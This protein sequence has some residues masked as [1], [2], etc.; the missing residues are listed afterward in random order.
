[1]K[2]CFLHSNADSKELILFF[3]GFASEPSHF[4]HLSSSKNVLM[5]YEYTNFDIDFD[6]NAFD[7]VTLIAFSMGV[8]IAAILAKDIK[9][10]IDYKIAINGTNYGIHR[11]YGIHPLIFSKTIENLNVLEFRKMLF[12]NHF[13]YMQGHYFRSKQ[14]LKEEL[15]SLYTFVMEN[16][17]GSIDF[18]YDKALL[19]ESDLVFPYSHSKKFFEQFFPNAFIISKDAPHFIFLDIDSWDK[20]CI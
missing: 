14:L 6:I 13:E 12:G 11:Q 3:A 19:S 9:S 7:S 8:S 20:L 2:T 5:L 10:K 4:A 17:M 15:Q 18:S 1:M 16:N